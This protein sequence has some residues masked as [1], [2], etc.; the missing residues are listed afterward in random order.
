M[1]MGLQDAV[2]HV[3]HGVIDRVRRNV[4]GYAICGLCAVV[5]LVLGI[6]AA[7]NALIPV[8]GVVY[9]QLIVAGFFVVVI[10]GTL[11]WL[12]RAAA[13]PSSQATPLGAAMTG[14]TAGDIRQRQVQF[15]QLAMIIEAVAL[16]YSLSRRRR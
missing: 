13:R 1:A 6:S 12:Q 2:T 16:G 4:I 3:L 8:V 15:A 10:I 7:V 5:V 14:A 9:A 11:L